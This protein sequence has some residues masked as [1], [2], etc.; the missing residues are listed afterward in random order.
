WY[1]HGTALIHVG[2]T[3][4]GLREFQKVLSINPANTNTGMRIAAALIYQ[5]KY[6]EAIA[7]LDRVPPEVQPATWVSFRALS[8]ITLNRLRDEAAM[9]D[10]ALAGDLEGGGVMRGVRAMLRAKLGN[11]QGA[12]A[13]VTAAVRI[14]KNGGEFHHTMYYIAAVYSVLGDLEKAQMWI[15]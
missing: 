11:R 5:H 14:G 8:L 10:G 2:H 4:Q 1:F 13:D 15:E 12:E 3:D 9:L 7:Q 6:E